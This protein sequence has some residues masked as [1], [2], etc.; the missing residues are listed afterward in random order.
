MRQWLVLIKGVYYKIGSRNKPYEPRFEKVVEVKPPL[1]IED[2]RWLQIEDVADDNSVLV[3]TVTIDEPL[4]AT[5][6]AQDSADALQKTIDDAFIAQKSAKRK[7]REFGMD[8]FDEIQVINDTKGW[9]VPQV[10]TFFANSNIQIIKVALETGGLETARDTML[11]TDL[12]SFYTT[13]EISDIAA[14]L[15]NYLDNE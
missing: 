3:P 4:K 11:A 8:L 14:K 5:I 15:T 10:L 9:T 1:D 6:Q 2:E 7:R 12:S 13:Q